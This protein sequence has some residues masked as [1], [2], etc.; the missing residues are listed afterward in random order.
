[1]AEDRGSLAPDKREALQIILRGIGLE[2]DEVVLARLAPQAPAVSEL[3]DDIAQLD[4]SGSEPAL[5]F[6]ARWEE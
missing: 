2:A 6:D 3:G 5:A 4:L 1:M